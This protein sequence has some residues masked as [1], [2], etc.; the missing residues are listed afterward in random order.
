[1]VYPGYSM[2]VRM[3]IFTFCETEENL[4]I[5]YR[6]EHVVQIKFKTASLHDKRQLVRPKGY[7]LILFHVYG[8]YIYRSNRHDMRSYLGPIVVYFRNSVL[9]MNIIRKGS[10]KHLIWIF[11]K[12]PEIWLATLGSSTLIP[13]LKKTPLDFSIGQIIC[14]TNHDA[15]FHILSLPSQNIE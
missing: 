8:A 1:M 11:S 14:Y 9:S 5:S 12:L 7:R 3:D 15:Q 13:E 2:P 10:V 4:Q 6:S